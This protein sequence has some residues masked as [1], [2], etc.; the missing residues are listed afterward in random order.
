[1]SNFKQETLVLE[2][3]LRQGCPPRVRGQKLFQLVQET[4]QISKGSWTT[5][6]VRGLE[7]PQQPLREDVFGIHACSLPS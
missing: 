2:Q 3:D 5:H 4:L 6:L 1:M 7:R